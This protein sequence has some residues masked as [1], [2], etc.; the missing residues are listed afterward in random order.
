MK[1]ALFIRLLLLLLFTLLH[2]IEHRTDIIGFYV[3]RGKA[4]TKRKLRHSIQTN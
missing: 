2:V 1:I 3:E 4:I